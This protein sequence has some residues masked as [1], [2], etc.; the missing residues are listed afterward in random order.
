MPAHADLNV[1]VPAIGALQSAIDFEQDVIAFKRHFCDLNFIAKPRRLTHGQR[2]IVPRHMV[3]RAVAVEIERLLRP[4]YGH[5]CIRVF[6]RQAAHQF[7]LFVFGQFVAGV[8]NAG[9]Q[10]RNADG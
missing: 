6:R 9:I 4:R 8:Q 1:V 2:A 7:D 3:V 10:K 5:F